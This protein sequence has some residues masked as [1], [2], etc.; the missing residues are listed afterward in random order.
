MFIHS[1]KTSTG[2][3]TFLKNY[4]SWHETILPYVS[5]ESLVDE[6]GRMLG[7]WI[8]ASKDG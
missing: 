4:A 3:K 1:A 5:L 8:R 2:L 6:I 7:G